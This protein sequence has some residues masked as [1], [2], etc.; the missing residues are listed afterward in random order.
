MCFVALICRFSV[1]PKQ[2][3]H[4]RIDHMDKNTDVIE[5]L[6]N[7]DEIDDDDGVLP[8]G[9]PASSEIV[10]SDSDVV[11][12]DS[13]LQIIEP[14]QHNKCRFCGVLLG[15]KVALGFCSSPPCK[16]KGKAFCA[17]TLPCGH[18]CGGVAGEKSPHPAC[19]T[20]EQPEEICPICRCALSDEPAL[21]LACLHGVHLDCVQSLIHSKWDGPRITFDQCT[22]C[23]VCRSSLSHPALSTALTPIL[24]IKS[25]VE[26]MALRRIVVEGLW[27]PADKSPAGQ[28][29]AAAAA[30]AATSSSSSSSSLSSSSGGGGSS[31][32]LIETQREYA[33]QKLSYYCCSKCRKPYFAGL[34]RCEAADSSADDGS[35]SSSSSPAASSE[36]TFSQKNRKR[37]HQDAA[38]ASAAAVASSSSYAAAGAGYGSSSSAHAAAGAGYGSSPSST[39]YAAGTGY[40][41]GSSSSSSSSSAAP[42]PLLCPECRPPPIGAC[43]VHNN[44][45]SLTVYK[46][47]YCCSQATHACRGGVNHYCDKCHDIADK[48]ARTNGTVLDWKPILKKDSWRHCVYSNGSKACPLGLAHPPHGHVAPFVIGCCSCMS[49]A[50]VARKQKC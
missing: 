29:V 40:G 47:K 1:S 21:V 44:D 39:G 8:P 5:I 38:A 28:A 27:P 10:L 42:A 13:E 20:C 19:F 31:S 22:R 32:L 16:E 43:A 2:Y 25:T 15:G 34:A 45:A 50:E 30:A 18:F 37:K 48:N 7:D 14:Q 11:G 35:E 23:P 26:S 41:F 3:I 4:P 9:A 6:D 17:T 33:M 24:Q 49:E 12:D 46:C 36:P